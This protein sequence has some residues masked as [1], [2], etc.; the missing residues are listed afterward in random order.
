M[1]VTYLDNNATTRP[2]PSVIAAMMEVLQ[3]D[4]GNPS[5]G[6]RVG[7]RA[8]F[9]VQRAR[10]YVAEAL[11]ADA[12]DVVFTA[13]GT[14][15]DMLAIRGVL[16]TQSDKRHWITV[17]TE[18]DAVIT[19][20]EQLDT[21][22]WTHTRLA[23]DRAGM[24]DLD[25]LDAA[26]QPDTALVSI[27]LANNETGVILPIAE[28]AERC[29]DRGVV[30]HTDAVQAVGKIPVYVDEL[31]VDLLSLS[32]HKI[33]GPKGTGALYVRRGTP[34]R[35]M[36]VGG[37]QEQDRRG[38]TEN[39]PGIVGFGEAMRLVSEDAGASETRVRTLRDRMESAIATVTPDIT[40]IGAAAPRLPNTSCIGF[41]GYSGEQILIALSEVGISASGGSACHSGALTPSRILSAMGVDLPTAG[42]AVR[43]SLS[44]YSEDGDVDT[45]LSV[46]PGI[47]DPLKKAARSPS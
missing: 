44:R 7:Q 43:L 40:V 39:V 16:T 42:G 45:L 20:S 27:M 26:F 1:A 3:T 23:V 38:G 32:S 10:Q 37:H 36:Q 17:Q 33:Y 21:E 4:F 30:S 46:L 29:R 11:H 2:A 8:A 31:G 13:G 35:P 14:E 5:S 41:T 6:H 22:G 24:I 19:L 28:I 18:H 9:H 12:D 25:E 34:L 15:S 47:L